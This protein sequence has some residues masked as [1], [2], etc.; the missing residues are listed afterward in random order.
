MTGGESLRNT[1]SFFYFFLK[2]YDSEDIVKGE[3]KLFL[4]YAK[5]QGSPNMTERKTERAKQLL[6][7]YIRDRQMTNG[8]KLPPQN[9]LR[10]IFRYGAATISSAINA[11]KSDGVLDVRDKV[12]N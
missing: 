1:V 9:E 6:V 10:R 12:G 7:R 4:V 5:Q 8:D 11:L 2:K 3:R